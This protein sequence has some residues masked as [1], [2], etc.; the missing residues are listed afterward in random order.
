[1]TLVILL[2]SLSA[3]QPTSIDLVDQVRNSVPVAVVVAVVDSSAIPTL[4]NVPPDSASA[5]PLGLDS[6]AT[7]RD[8]HPSAPSAAPT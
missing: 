4:G 3:L 7:R 2:V 5:Q 8:G 6:P 1:M